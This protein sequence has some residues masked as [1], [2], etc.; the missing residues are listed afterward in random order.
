M[1]SIYMS[2]LLKIINYCRKSLLAPYR[3]VRPMNQEIHKDLYKSKL[4]NEVLVC[5]RKGESHLD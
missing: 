2:R 4:V 3:H 1:I 5:L